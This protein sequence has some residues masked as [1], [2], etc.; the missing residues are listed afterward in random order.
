MSVAHELVPRDSL[1][2]VTPSY[3]K[4]LAT[5]LQPP[6]LRPGFVIRQS[7][8]DLLD[9]SADRHII[10]VQAPAG[11]GKSTVVAQW[12]AS[13]GTTGAW[14][15]LDAWDDEPAQFFAGIVAAMRTIDPGFGVDVMAQIDRVG[16]VRD[17]GILGALIEELSVVVCRCALV[18]DDVHLIADPGLLHSLSVLLRNIPP[19]MRVF[20]LSRGDLALQLQRLRASGDL[21]DIGYEQLRFT[22][23]EATALFSADSQIE[24]SPSEI[25]A[26][27]EQSEGWPAALNLARHAVRGQQHN[28]VEQLIEQG[29]FERRLVTGY[30]WEEVLQKLER[31]LLDFLVHSA[32][33]ERF[34]AE[35]CDAA[36]NRDDSAERIAE[37]D[38]AGLFVVPLDTDGQ[39]FRYHHLFRDVLQQRQRSKVT[40]GELSTVHR[41]AADWFH[42]QNLTDEVIRHAICG[43]DWDRAIAL[44]EP[45]A[46]NLQQRD[47]IAALQRRLE[48]LPWN[49]LEMHP[50]FSYLLAWARA[51]AGKITESMA[52]MKVAE[53]VWN[54]SADTEN[55]GRLQLLRSMQNAAISEFSAAHDAVDR[56]IE[57]L[58]E[59]RSIERALAYQFK[60]T[61]YTLIG[62][63][64]EAAFALTSSN[65]VSTLDH[66]S[67]LRRL[68]AIS[69][70]T[71][72]AM[73]ADLHEAEELFRY[74][75]RSDQGSALMQT[76]HALTHLGM[77]LLEQDRREEAEQCFNR[78]LRFSDE[79]STTLWR[80]RF[81]VGLALV[82][83]A[84]GDFEL[85]HAEIERALHQW[86]VIGSRH[87]LEKSKALQ[88][89]FWID[90]N[91]L[92]LPRRWSEEAALPNPDERS[93][94]EHHIAYSTEIRLLLAEGDIA[95]AV[96]LSA[97]LRSI[98][99]AQERWHD[100]IELDV[101]CALAAHA[102]GDTP[103][104]LTALTA[105]LAAAE[106]GRYVRV[107][108]NNG[109]ALAPL[110]HTL[111][112]KNDYRDYARKLLVT[113]EG[114]ETAHFAVDQ[115]HL[116]ET[117]SERELD[118][119]R[120]VS[121]GLSNKAIGD[122]L[123]ITDKTAKKHISNILGKLRASNRT[124]AVDRA[125]RL[126]LLVD[127]WRETPS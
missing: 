43:E 69:R 64:A 34:S 71:I 24:L 77:L 111:L 119:L 114:H 29:A 3:R 98:A 14:L 39:W 52:P 65:V 125:R 45:V 44:L 31:P 89:R 79:A 7:I 4:V 40:A 99:H 110:L 19:G 57:L 107:F 53:S 96:R 55:L 30:L 67:P 17:Q 90:A 127:S 10:N 95:R 116:S 49:V 101:L 35:L 86:S 18:L 27:T 72:R 5:K 87:E 75:A 28:L 8:L 33:F 13:T 61:I 42:A 26:F 124:Q 126:G 112:A 105:A 104:A 12:L 81:L 60:S 74:A 103:A 47:Q 83:R 36:L 73:Q 78:G 88:A 120:L 102:F 115:S 51:R 84:E 117:L 58:P 21:L 11:Y 109:Q 94:P 80:G 23:E 76:Q 68:D 82:A 91:H 93:A 32:A 85:A 59:S 38:A 46:A 48:F 118:V 9:S 50:E 2:E 62:L 100:R 16:P 37:L 121:I 113:V 22:S 41:R 20:L 92:S 106:P 6:R 15:S 66:A 63:P 97:A 122:R 123:F 56:A 25:V 1:F 70:G 108:V 54:A